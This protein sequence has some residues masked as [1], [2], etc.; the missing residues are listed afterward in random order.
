L[1]FNEN[2][3]Q[4]AEIND[5]DE[6]VLNDG[7][8]IGHRSLHLIYKQRNTKDDTQTEEQ[9]I[10]KINNPNKK[11]ILQQVIR[12]EDKKAFEESGMKEGNILI[13]QARDDSSINYQTRKHKLD[14]NYYKNKKQDVIL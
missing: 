6:I 5:N 1:P 10:S 2:Q 12:N 7:S 9:L 13:K 11:F 3:K 4:I 8:I 14:T